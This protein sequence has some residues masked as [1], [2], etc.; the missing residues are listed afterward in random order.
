MHEF[1]TTSD[2]QIVHLHVSGKLDESDYEKI[3]PAFEERIASFGKIN[4]LWEM[5]DF[6]GWT[7]KGLWADTQ[8]DVRH[9]NDFARIAMVGEK[10]WQKLITKAM[11]PFTSAEVRYYETSVL[12]I[13]LKWVDHVP[14]E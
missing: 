4:L 6:H 3:V 14:K 8:F 2:P 9:A 1:I 5:T 13:A 12:D 7:A 11:S 10:Q